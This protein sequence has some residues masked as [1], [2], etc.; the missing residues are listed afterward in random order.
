MWYE[1]FNREYEEIHTDIE[2]RLSLISWSVLRSF[3]NENCKGTN[4]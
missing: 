1:H 2:Q 4:Q 3:A